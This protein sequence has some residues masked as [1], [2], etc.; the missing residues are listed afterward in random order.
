MQE[1]ISRLR[2]TSYG[3]TKA[4][5]GNRRGVAI[6]EPLVTLEQMLAQLPEAIDFDLEISMRR[7]SIVNLDELSRR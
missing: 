1:M 5:K 3:P 4:V 6:Q 7:P 2:V